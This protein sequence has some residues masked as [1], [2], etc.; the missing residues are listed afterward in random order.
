MLKPDRMGAAY[1][2]DHGQAVHCEQLVVDLGTDQ[3]CLRRKQL[4]A[5]EECAQP[6]GD[7]K[8]EGGHQVALADDL[9]IDRR[10][11]AV[12]AR[13]L[14]PDMSERFNR[15]VS[16]GNGDGGSHGDQPPLLECLE[17][18]HERSHPRRR[19]RHARH[20]GA[21]LDGLWIIDPPHQIAGGV[22]QRP[23]R[24]HPA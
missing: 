16:V 9:V 13:L 5:H 21:W 7:E 1:Q 2:N 10:Q 22:W 11:H 6:R 23:S 18:R 12:Q 4:R 19:D 15:S 20:V 3:M 17:I 24:Q 14:L 8:C